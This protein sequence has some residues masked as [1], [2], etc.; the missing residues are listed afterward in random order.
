MGTAP[1]T[2]TAEHTQPRHRGAQVA[3]A[4]TGLLAVANLVF[5]AEFPIADPTLILAALATCAAFSGWARTR[6]FVGVPEWRLVA[7]GVCFVPGVLLAS[8]PYSG[9]KMAGMALGGIV[10]LGSVEEPLERPALHDVL[11][12]VASAAHHAA[13]SLSSATTEL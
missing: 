2:L 1:V 6:F 12:V 4:T 10:A 3:G 11:L 8:G 5:P 7:L 13:S 9:Q